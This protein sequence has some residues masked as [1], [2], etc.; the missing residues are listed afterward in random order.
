MFVDSKLMFREALIAR[1]NLEGL[2]AAELSRKTGINKGTIDKMRQRRTEAT[3]VA[4]AMKIAKYFNQSVEEF[5]GLGQVTDKAAE[6][7][8]LAL[9]LPAEFQEVMVAHL[10]A[11]IAIRKGSGNL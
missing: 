5:C 9:L 1:L 7:T 3:N 2:S 6:I 4:D 10:K 8:K 11:I